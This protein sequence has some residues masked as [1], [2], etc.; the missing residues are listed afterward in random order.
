MTA[1]QGKL[2]RASCV[3][4]Q[5]LAGIFRYTVEQ[6]AFPVS[7]KMTRTAAGGE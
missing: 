2:F 4:D 6:A 3:K 7:E 5:E 1:D